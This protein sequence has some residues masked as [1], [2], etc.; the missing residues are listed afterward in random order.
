MSHE[1]YAEE[2]EW[3]SAHKV[4]LQ[5]SP[6]N[7]QIDLRC[8]IA[9]RIFDSKPVYVQQQLEANNNAQYQAKLATHKQGVKHAQAIMKGI[10]SQ[11]PYNQDR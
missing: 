4:A 2:V 3:A 7:L 6:F 10:P 11:N 5:S 9:Q 8:K 1:D